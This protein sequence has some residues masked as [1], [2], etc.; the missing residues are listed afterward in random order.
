MVQSGCGS[1][2]ALKSIRELFVGHLN[3]DGAPKSGVASAIHFAHAA[4]SDGCEDFVRPQFFTYCK[5][6]ILDSAKFNGSTSGHETMA[7]K[8]TAAP[9]IGLSGSRCGRIVGDPY[10]ARSG[11]QS[12]EVAV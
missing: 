6:H 11:D 4:R 2:F 3:G 1:G 5:T 7:R 12:R 9:E 8:R 10:T